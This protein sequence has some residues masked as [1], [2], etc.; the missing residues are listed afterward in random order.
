MVVR[1]TNKEVEINI[2]DVVKKIK[3]EIKQRIKSRP[4]G[5]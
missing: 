5:I 3:I 2:E 4:W 1:F